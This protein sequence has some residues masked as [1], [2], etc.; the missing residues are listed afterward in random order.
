MPY[1]I[2]AYCKADCSE[3]SGSVRLDNMQSRQIDISL[4]RVTQVQ[5]SCECY[6]LHRDETSFLG[7]PIH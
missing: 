6:K 5:F 3:G 1:Y 7:V 4:S 2:E